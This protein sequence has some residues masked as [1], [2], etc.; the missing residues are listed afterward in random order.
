MKSML[1]FEHVSIEYGGKRALSDFC[2]EIGDGEF[3]SLIGPNGSGKSTLINAFIGTVPLASGAIYLQGKDNKRYSSKK[4]AQVAA[5]VPQY[6]NT[7]FAF[8]VRDIVM[9]GRN[10]YIKRFASETPEDLAIVNDALMKTD[11][12]PLKDRKITMLSGGERQRVVISAA[13]AQTPKLLILDEPTNHLDLSHT[14][15]IMQL[16]KELNE[17]EGMTVLAVL[18]DIN[19]AARYSDRICLVNKGKLVK[20][21]KVEEVISEGVLKPV[22]EIDLVVRKN[23]LTE[24]MEIVPL[25]KTKASIVQGKGR[26]HVVCGGGSGEIFLEEL[27]NSGYNIS[28]G[29]L[30]ASDSDAACCSSLGIDTILEAPYSPVSEVRHQE[31]LQTMRQAQAIVLTDVPFGTGN[32]KNLEAV[33]AAAE[34]KRIPVFLVAAQERDFVGGRADAILSALKESSMAEELGERDLLDRIKEGS[35]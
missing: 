22:Y 21:G 30:N 19:A 7:S 28:C 31:N 26:I 34:E 29:V 8:T 1:R 10:P 14:L 15:Q 18:H 12:M 20:A 5:V 17:K 2:F 6:F 32:L 11:S 4:R 23:R 27:R 25:R 16:A 33:K 9:M 3:V 24:S 13:L 35:I